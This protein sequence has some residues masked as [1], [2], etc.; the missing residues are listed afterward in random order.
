MRSPGT[1]T[2]WV[3]LVI[4]TFALAT[5]NLA[6]LLPSLSPRVDA[7]TGGEPVLDLRAGGYGPLEAH[8]F[9][10][11]LG[12]H[13][14]RLYLTLLWTLDVFMPALLS[15]LLWTSLSLGTLRR[16]RWAGLLGGATDGLENV[17]TSGLLLSFPNEP[18]GLA[19]LGGTLVTIKFALYLSGAAL[20]AAGWLALQARR[21]HCPGGAE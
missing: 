17:A 12:E 9:L 19:R 16:W 5:V 18:A 3:L 14:R 20:A 13:G 11:T 21:P 2:W 10:D 8:R 1:R 6:P 4:T 15:A 7:F